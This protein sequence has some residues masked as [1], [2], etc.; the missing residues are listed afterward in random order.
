M[1]DASLLVHARRTRVLPEEHRAKIF[2]TKT[3]HSIDTFLVDG[4]IAG[5][6]RYDDGRITLKPFGKLPPRVHGRAP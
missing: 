6:W 2:N 5:T 3:P 1:W 4:K